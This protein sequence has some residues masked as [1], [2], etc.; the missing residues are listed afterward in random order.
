LNPAGLALD[1]ENGRIGAV[2]A[3][4]LDAGDL[5][6]A[7]ER[8]PDLEGVG[9][10]PHVVRGERLAVHDTP[11]AAWSPPTSHEARVLRLPRAD[12][13]A[14]G[15]VAPGHPAATPFR[16]EEDATDGAHDAPRERSIV[17]Q[18]VR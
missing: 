9:D 5:D 12:P 16:R 7:G 18:R 14:V 6:A 10:R 3:H 15:A 11:Q 2:S 13:A 8:F 4:P 17:L 1:E